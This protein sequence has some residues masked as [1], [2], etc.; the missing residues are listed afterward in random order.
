MRDIK[1]PDRIERA[2]KTLELYAK[3]KG[4]K[5]DYC[6]A[7][8]LIADLLHYEASEFLKNNASAGADDVPSHIDA[9]MARS[10]MHFDAEF[11]NPEEE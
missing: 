10:R 5:V 6:E 7:T 3:D 9:L 1:N 8:D 4:E 2:R 11:D